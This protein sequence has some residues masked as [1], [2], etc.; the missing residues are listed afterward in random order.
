MPI[1]QTNRGKKAA[2]TRAENAERERQATEQLAKEMEGKR[3]NVTCPLHVP[4]L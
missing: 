2:Q 1:G 3:G 4:L